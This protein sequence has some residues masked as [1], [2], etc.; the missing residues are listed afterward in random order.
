MLSLLNRI[1]SAFKKVAKQAEFLLNKE[2]FL[3]FSKGLK[4]G[5]EAA[6]PRVT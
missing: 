3:L 1:S 2:E 4:R 6:E 5:E